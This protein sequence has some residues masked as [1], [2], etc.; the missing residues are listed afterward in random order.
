MQKSYPVTGMTCAACARRVE[1]LAAKQPGVAQAGVNYA[2]ERLTLEADPDVF[3][4]EDLAAAIAKAGYGVELPS[5]LRG[6]V[7]PVAGMTCAA[8]AARIQKGLSR[9]PGVA[10]ANVNYAAETAHVSYDPALVKLSELRAAIEKLGYTPLAGEAAQPD[11]AQARKEAALK[12]VWRRFVVAASFAAPLLY[13]AMAPMLPGLPGG[14]LPEVLRP[15][16]NP[17]LY[18]VAQLCLV[19]PVLFVGRRFYT[20]GFRALWQRSPNM[21]SLI[22]VGTAAATLYSVWST[23]QIAGGMHHAVHSL[24]FE[25]AGVIIALILLGKALEA[26]SRGRAGDAIRQLMELA[27]KT[28]TLLRG[29]DEVE[30]PVSEVEPGDVLLVRPG[31]KLPVDGVVL[32][33]HTAVDESMLTGESLPVDKSWGDRVFAA[34]LNRSG[35]IKMRATNVGGETALAQIIRLVE[36]AQGSKAPIARLAD[37]V[38]GIFVP[39]VIGIALLAGGAWLLAGES[40]RF[41]LTIF[42]SVLV[43]ACP[44]A[45]GLAT[46]TAIMVGTGRGA[47]M[48]ILIRG[49]AALETAHKTQAVVFDKTGTLTLGQ[50]KVTDI[51]PVGG[52]RPGPL[53]LAAASAEHG[54]EHPLGQAIVAYARE[55]GMTLHPT[56]RFEAVPGRGVRATVDGRGYLVGNSRLMEDAGIELGGMAEKAAELAADGKTPMFVADDGGLLG[57]IAV[58]DVVK[59]TSAEAVRRLAGMGLDVVMLTG[60][61]KA[62]AEAIA[63]QLGVTQVIAEVLPGDKAAKI[64]ELQKA[65]KRVAMVGDGI[66]DAPALAQADVGIAVGTGADVALESAGIVLMRG[67]LLDVPAALA[68]SRATMR[69]VRQNLFWAFGY[70]TVGIPVAAGLLHLFGGPLLNPMLAAAAMSLS[71]VSVLTNALRLRGMKL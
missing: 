31:A 48:G 30:I 12:A 62:T 71:S 5:P 67:D 18:A 37:V 16:V 59:D 9:L 58:A 1:K 40:P 64:T 70:N 2:A 3:S 46:P 66:N 47:R 27:P 17:L 13:L 29:G 69:V 6:T 34:T 4:E 22:A 55:R 15:D 51:L 39:A 50:P 32:D 26:R 41:S 11:A 52:A 19:L 7:V 10:E 63:R 20:V 28:A 42:I 8:C 49:G 35:S 33:G 61:G 44:C 56:E 68:L 38:S 54:S 23:A 43:I 14:G 36:D 21:D 57:I 45:L 53:L 60:D 25:S 24:Y 65:G